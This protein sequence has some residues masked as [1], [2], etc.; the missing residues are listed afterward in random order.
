M[1]V[2]VAACVA[3]AEGLPSVEGLGWPDAS[4]C[5]AT[6]AVCA[7][8]PE[9]LLRCW[10]VAAIPPLLIATGG[11][12]GAARL[13][14]VRVEGATDVETKDGGSFRFRDGSSFWSGTSSTTCLTP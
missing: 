11:F 4:G 14:I 10:T 9:T 13:R 8:S 2:A 12:L 1:A 3:W 5:H 7:I 6:V